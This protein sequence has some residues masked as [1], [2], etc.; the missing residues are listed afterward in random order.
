MPP[1]PGRH[2]GVLVGGVVVED[3]VDCLALRHL[4]LDGVEEA[5]EFLMAMALHAAPDDLAFENVE[6]GEQGGGAIALV[7]VSHRG[8]APLLDRQSGLGAVKGLDLALLVD[9]ED[10]RMRR[11]IDIEPDHRLE[12]LGEFG[13]VGQLE[14]AY[15]MRLQPMPF[16]MRRTE[17][18]LIS[19]TL[20]MAGAVQWVASCGGGW[21]VNAM[22]RSTF[23]AGKGGMREGRVLSRVS[24]STPHAQSAPASAIPPAC[25]CRP[26]A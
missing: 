13:V 15:P 2:L 16:Q 10:D 17:E 7:I 22:T 5:D 26:H 25:P 21:L 9:A 6:G 4:G 11:R 20:A 8:A 19:T 1:Q 18:G 14:M 24:P 23:S 12:L 3:H